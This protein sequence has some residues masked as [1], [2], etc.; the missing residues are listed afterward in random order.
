LTGNYLYSSVLTDIET[1]QQED[2]LIFP[3]PTD[4]V[5]FFD[6]KNTTPAT[7][8]LYD[9]QGKYLRRQ[10]LAQDNQLSVRHLDSGVYF[11]QLLIDG[12]IFGGK[13]VVK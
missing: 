11:Y 9:A 7:I 10:A 1:P 12:E 8:Q 2:I 13:F 4:E 5:I 6:I 3:N